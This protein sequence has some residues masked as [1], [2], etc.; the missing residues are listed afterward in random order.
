MPIESSAAELLP[1]A[2]SDPQPSRALSDDFLWQELFHF[3]SSISFL[4]HNLISSLYNCSLKPSYC[5]CAEWPTADPSLSNLE[6]HF[7]FSLLSL[8]DAAQFLTKP[9]YFRDLGSQHRPINKQKVIQNLVGV[10]CKKSKEIL[11][12]IPHRLVVHWTSDGL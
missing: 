1:P 7:S 9:A 8:W 10:E 11:L 6:A 4:C 3:T 5:F 2:L 12:G